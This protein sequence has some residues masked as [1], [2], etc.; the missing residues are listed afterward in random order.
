MELKAS[1]IAQDHGTAQ[2]APM[3]SWS[4]SGHTT[5][6]GIEN[7][8]CRTGMSDTTVDSRYVSPHKLSDEASYDSDCEID[9]DIA[10]LLNKAT[11]RTG[12]KRK[13]DRLYISIEDVLDYLQKKKCV[14]SL[15]ITPQA[16]RLL[17][18]NQLEALLHES[19]PVNIN[20]AMRCPQLKDAQTQTEP[21]ISNSES[22]TD[23]SS[24]IDG[25]E[26]NHHGSYSDDDDED[27]PIHYVDSPQQRV[28]LL[29]MLGYDTPRFVQFTINSCGGVGSS[30]ESGSASGNSNNAGN[31]K[32]TSS[33]ATTNSSG[34]WTPGI[35][36]G[37]ANDTKSPR[38]NIVAIDSGIPP[39][40]LAF[41]PLELKCWH[42]ACGFR[43]PGNK[44]G[45]STEVRRLL[46]YVLSNHSYE[47]L[48][49]LVIILSRR[50]AVTTT[51]YHRN[52]N[53]A[54]VY[55]RMRNSRNNTRINFL[56]PILRVIS[57]LRRNSR[58]AMR[59]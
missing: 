24:D 40:Q 2:S 57:Y 53:V 16:Q 12:S 21:E 45:T 7:A 54:I 9:D 55:L 6:S 48:I 46:V 10:V 3:I 20:L 42:A 31:G 52:A 1:N 58:I 34:P 49:S 23:R 13:Q 51:S 39:S 50:R 36:P 37:I 4:G 18:G 11:R 44:T 19:V 17:S 38:D 59:S 35:Q 26:D 29:H 8:M 14:G 47:I 5:E 56:N 43:C 33:P 32:A 22:A 41:K 30:S 25:S 28:D 27:D 15:V